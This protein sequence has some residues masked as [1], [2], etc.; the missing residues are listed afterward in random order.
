L[1]KQE[2]GFSFGNALQEG[3][4]ETIREKDPTQSS[5]VKRKREGDQAGPGLEKKES[6]P[7]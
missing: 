1:H 5:F 7:L 3:A 4:L 6:P 2:G